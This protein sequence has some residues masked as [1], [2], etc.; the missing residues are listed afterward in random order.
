MSLQ[1]PLPELP[2]CCWQG[3]GL[4]SLCPPLS[5]QASWASAVGCT[6]APCQSRWWNPWEPVSRRVESCPALSLQSQ[7]Q[8]QHCTPLIRADP[9]SKHDSDKGHVKA[10]T[11]AKPAPLCK[12]QWLLSLCPFLTVEI[13]TSYHTRGE[14]KTHYNSMQGVSGSKEKGRSVKELINK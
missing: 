3:Q 6:L 7:V 4:P 10:V 8:T 2:H 11:A 1:Q 5:K 13:R 12:G 14:C 9:G